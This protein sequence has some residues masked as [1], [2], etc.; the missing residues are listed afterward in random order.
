MPFCL[1]IDEVQGCVLVRWYGRVSLGDARAFHGEIEALPGFRPGLKRY[2]DLRR[3]DVDLNQ[4]EIR[5]IAEAVRL[6]DS[7]H[8]ERQA[9]FLVGSDAA[10]GV[11]RMLMAVREPCNVT[12]NV[13][14]DFDRDRTWLKLPDDYEDPFPIDN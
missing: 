6:G 1:D 13:F 14:R 5:S 4:A 2:H 7:R 3:A 12:L 8:G 11:A 9:V 10:F